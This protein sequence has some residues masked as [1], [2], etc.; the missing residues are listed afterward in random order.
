MLED[1]LRKSPLLVAYFSQED[2]PVCK[3]LRPKV[4]NL[5]DSF[6]GIEFLYIDI[7][8]HPAISGQYLVFSIPTIILFVSGKE[9]TRFSRHFSMD[10]LNYT[11]EYLHDVVFGE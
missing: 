6:K 4:E 9:H 7:K 1:I 5:V 8:S 2:C 11:L 10:D 3:V